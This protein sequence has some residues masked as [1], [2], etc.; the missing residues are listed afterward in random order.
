MTKWK[1]VI[2]V[3]VAGLGL[4]AAPVGAGTRVE[5]RQACAEATRVC[6]QTC[7]ESQV[8]GLSARRCR[9]GCRSPRLLAACLRLC[10]AGS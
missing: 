8:S 5:C 3:T 2:V 1:T 4:W 6:V 9:A 7:N 10:R